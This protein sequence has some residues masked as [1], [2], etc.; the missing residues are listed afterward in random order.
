MKNKKIIIITSVVVGVLLL[1]GVVGAGVVMAQNAGSQPPI[2]EKL[3]KKLNVSTNDVGAAFD[4]LRQ[5]R[6]QE[7]QDRFEKELEQA[8]KDGKITAE[9]KEVILK[10]QAAISEK[11]EEVL[12]LRQELM[13]WA[14]DNN[15]APELL[16]MRGPGHGRG[17]PGGGCFGPGPV[18]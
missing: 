10:K 12:K 5:E 11:Q 7:V 13:N 4:E 8:V 14:D 17:G 9:Q 18:E 2:V 16:F 6:Q 15:I 3:A 1:A